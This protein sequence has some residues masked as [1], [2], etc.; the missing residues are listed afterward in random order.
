M[1]VLLVRIASFYFIKN[2][3]HIV[4]YPVHRIFLKL[5]RAGLIALC[6]HFTVYYIGKCADW[7]WGHMLDYCGC[8]TNKSHLGYCGA[9]N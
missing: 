7:T 4:A 6:R 2:N 1:G 9:S 8:F 5:N 3:E